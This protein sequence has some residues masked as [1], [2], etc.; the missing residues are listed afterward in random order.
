[1]NPQ[2]VTYVDGE[3]IVDSVKIDIHSIIELGVDQ[4]RINI[5]K[6]LKK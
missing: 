1:M 3:E 4:Y 5:K 6:L 2:N